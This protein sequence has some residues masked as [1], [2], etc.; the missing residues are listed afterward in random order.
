MVLVLRHCRAPF[1]L[2]I[3]KGSLCWKQIARLGY[4]VEIV[5]LG[6]FNPY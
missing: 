3:S 1:S 5:I 6:V 4:C 2:Y